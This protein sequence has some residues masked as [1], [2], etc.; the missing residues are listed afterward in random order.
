ME[1]SQEIISLV[2][3]DFISV[4]QQLVIDQLLSVELKHVMA[5]SRRNLNN[6]RLSIL[7]LAKGDSDAV[8]ELTQIAKIDFRDVI[9]WATLDN[10]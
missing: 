2:H 7:K 9:L 6:T 10:N 5:D 8:I 3:T 1:L 4:E